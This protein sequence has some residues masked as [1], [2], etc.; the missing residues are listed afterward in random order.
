MK[1][2]QFLVQAVGGESAG[3]ISAVSGQSSLTSL[4]VFA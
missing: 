1:S 4:L 2:V 3:S